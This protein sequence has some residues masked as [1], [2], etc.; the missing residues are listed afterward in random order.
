MLEAS[1]RLLEV[2][3][4]VEGALERFMIAQ[5][6]ARRVRAHLLLGILEPVHRMTLGAAVVYRERRLEAVELHALVPDLDES[7]KYLRA[8]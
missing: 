7:R 8:P 5:Q 2:A 6:L 4:R 1:L 3:L